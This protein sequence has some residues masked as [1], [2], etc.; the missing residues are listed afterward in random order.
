MKR[1]FLLLSLCA[2]FASSAFAQ[3]GKPTPV[4]IYDVTSTISDYQADGIT[5]HHLQSDLFGSYKTD[6]ATN[7]VSRLD[8]GDNSTWNIYMQE[9]TT[10]GVYVTF[11]P[12]SGNGL[13]NPLSGTKYL[14]AR[15]ISRCFDPTGLT[16]NTASWFNITTSN[17]NCSMRVNFTE[18]GTGTQ[19][20]LVM[21][22]LFDNTGRSIVRCT[23]VSGSTCSAWTI[24]P[25]LGSPSIVNPNPGVANL[26]SANPKNGKLTLVGTYRL[27]SYHVNVT[28]P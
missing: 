15:V 12:I 5:S 20:S 4:P 10:R 14:H 25:N 11:N 23:A 16:T 26:Y 17:P 27:D 22:P 13:P 6:S 2:L 24:T 21:S 8:S 28:Y 3:K 18:D 7:V 19:Y 9:S 1:T